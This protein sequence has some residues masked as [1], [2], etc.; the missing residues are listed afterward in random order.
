MLRPLLRRLLGLEGGVVS[1]VRF[2]AGLSLLFFGSIVLGVGAAI[3]AH[4]LHW[5][6]E[7]WTTIMA[8][9]LFILISGSLISLSA[10]RLRDIGCAPGFGLGGLL[11]LYAFEAFAPPIPWPSPLRDLT[12]FPLTTL[13]LWTLGFFLIFW[14]GRDEAGERRG[15]LLV[16]GA[17]AA[18]LIGGVGLGLVFDPQQGKVCPIYGAGAPSDDCESWGAIGRYYSSYQVVEANKRLDQREPARALTGLKRA[19]A[20][21][22][23]FV[24]AYNSLGLAYAQTND[25]TRALQAFDRALALQPG[26]VHGLI[27]RAMLLEQLGQRPRALADLREALR[28]DPNNTFAQQGIAQ[29]T[30]GR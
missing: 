9:V 17:M 11:L 7:I 1:R 23:Q 15:S 18:V 14:P 24:Y 21:R 19:I 12:R 8:I 20:V 3:V 6:S 4:V 10:R 5:P 13:G 27:N 16:P 2:L 22:P 30:G 29:L 28:Q 26:Y 25:T